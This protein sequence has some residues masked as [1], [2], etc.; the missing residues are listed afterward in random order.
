MSLSI[1]GMA[2]RLYRPLPTCAH[3][4]VLLSIASGAHLPLNRPLLGLSPSAGLWSQC[5]SRAQPSTASGYTFLPLS[6]YCCPCHITLPAHETLYCPGTSTLTPVTTH[7]GPGS[8]GKVRSRQRSLIPS[9]EK[10][11]GLERPSCPGPAWGP[12]PWCSGPG[13]TPLGLPAPAVTSSLF[14]Q[15]TLCKTL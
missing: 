15:S 6:G 10:A 9:R 4:R 7:Y 1:S 2:S 5:Q 13:P 14:S 12:G 8:A 11:R 3:A